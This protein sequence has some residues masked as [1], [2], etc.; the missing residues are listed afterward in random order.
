M[1][2]V[3][4][5]IVA[6]MCCQKEGC[7][8][9]LDPSNGILEAT[10][11]LLTSTSDIPTICEVI[12]LLRLLLWH[13]MNRTNEESRMTCPLLL[14]LQSKSTVQSLTFLAKNCLNGKIFQYRI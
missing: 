3:V 4:T 13:R 1:K 5:G 6:N 11:E 12:R 9:L 10:F 14:G 7:D 8:K 2:E